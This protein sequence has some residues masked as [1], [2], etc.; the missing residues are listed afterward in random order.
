MSDDLLTVHANVLFRIN[1][2]NRLVQLNESD[3]EHPAPYVFLARGQNSNLC[4]FR[5]DVDEDFIAEFEARLAALPHWVDGQSK[6]AIFEPL[7][8]VLKKRFRSFT[9]SHGPA[10]HFPQDFIGEPNSEAVFIAEENAGVLAQNYPYTKSVLAERSPI[11]AVVRDGDAV[12]ACYCARKTYA[13]AEAGVDTI[14]AFR[15]QGLALEV[16]SAWAREVGEQK[17][18]PLYSTNWGNEASLAIARRLGLSQYADTLAFS[19][20]E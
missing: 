5:D 4:L 15:G 19:S 1:E 9:E 13:A 3:P 12:S 20:D 16:V 11:A 2:N 10:F 8:N 6:S 7:R 14:S 17:L 18:L